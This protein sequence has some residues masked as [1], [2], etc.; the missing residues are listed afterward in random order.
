MKSRMYWLYCNHAAFIWYSF[1]EILFRIYA[2]FVITWQQEQSRFEYN[3]YVYSVRV[4]HKRVVAGVMDK[5]VV[6]GKDTIYTCIYV[7]LTLKALL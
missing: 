4:Q 1:S 6:Y 5:K 7:V 3:I 2:A